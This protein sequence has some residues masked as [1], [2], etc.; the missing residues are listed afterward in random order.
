VSTAPTSTISTSSSSTSPAS[1]SSSTPVGAIVGGVVGGLALLAGI[2]A[3]IWYFARTPRTAHSNFQEQTD[4][5]FGDQ[6]IYSPEKRNE[7]EVLS[8]HNNVVGGR[9][10][11]A[12]VYPDTVPS[13][14]TIT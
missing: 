13:G 5:D 6:P 3:L 1:S 4:Q 8:E 14:R 12:L 10:S 2:V 11:Q 7:D 9:L